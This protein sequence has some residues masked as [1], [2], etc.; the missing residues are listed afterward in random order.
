MQHNLILEPIGECSPPPLIEP[1]PSQSP[2]TPPLTPVL[3]ID[4]ATESN[5][6]T[7]LTIACAGGHDDL[8]KLLLARG[9]NIEHRDKKGLFYGNPQIF[10]LLTQLCVCAVMPP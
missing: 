7:A 2:V 9:A 8:V 10:Y 3:N 5:H 6:D 4:Q 1:I